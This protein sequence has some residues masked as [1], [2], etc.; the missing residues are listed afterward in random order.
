MPKTLSL[1]TH[2]NMVEAENY[3]DRVLRDLEDDY[4]RIIVLRAFVTV[5]LAQLTPPEMEDHADWALAYL[6][7]E[8]HEKYE[9]F[10]NS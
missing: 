2:P 8:P 7:L 6:D 5:R 9:L 3:L 1:L 10:N 4:T